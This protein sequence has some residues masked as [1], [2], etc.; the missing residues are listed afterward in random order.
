MGWG[1]PAPLR[2]HGELSEPAWSPLWG[3]PGGLVPRSIKNGVLSLGGFFT[4]RVQYQVP[5]SL[6]SRRRVIADSDLDSDNI[7][8][9]ESDSIIV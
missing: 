5:P 2:C 1:R 7:T 4:V 8:E 6:V 3:W 9:S